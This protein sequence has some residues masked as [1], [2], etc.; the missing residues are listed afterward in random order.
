[1]SDSDN[2]EEIK[3]RSR[4]SSEK[5]DYKIDTEGLEIKEDDDDIDYEETEEI[6]GKKRP[7]EDEDMSEEEEEE[8]DDEDHIESEIASKPRTEHK[9][10]KAKQS[11]FGKSF[12]V[13]PTSKKSDIRYPIDEEG[14]LL[15]V[16]EYEYETLEDP[17]GDKKITKD[18][19]LLDGREFTIR[20]FTISEESTQKFML[21]TEVARTL[22]YRDSYMFFQYH[23]SVYKFVLSQQYK[24]YLI[25]NNIIPYSYRS[26]KI[27]LVAARS[28]FKDLGAKVVKNGKSPDDDYYVSVFPS[29]G[30]KP[31]PSPGEIK[32]Q[33]EEKQKIAT[34]SADSSKNQSPL[35]SNPVFI[36]QRAATAMGNAFTGNTK[37]NSTNWLYQ[38][39]A[40]C[41]RFNSD[42]YYDRVRVLLIEQQGLRDPYT[43]TLHIPQNVQSTRIV[44]WYKEEDESGE[45]KPEKIS[46]ETILQSQNI[47]L[48]K[49]GLN[50]VTSEIFEDVVDEDTLKAI[51][52]QQ[53]FES[54]TMTFEE[55]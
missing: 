42:L 22:G 4:T 20:T 46:C 30:Q 12:S 38:H 3:L 16:Y 31:K 48:P 49:T 26:R 24:N 34:A 11:A 43:N 51:R 18:G 36:E 52:K 19:D 6:R 1:M 7:R 50:C 8:D 14:Y 5:P 53:E 35:V 15:P 23:P 45:A 25:T 10:A 32:Q 37:L 40:A 54:N 47:T 29:R 9:R 39:A 17:E 44:D 33:K 27:G 28:I 2:N 55:V 41:S 13:G 21:S